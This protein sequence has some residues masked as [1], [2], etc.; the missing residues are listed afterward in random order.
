MSQPKSSSLQR[1]AAA[2]TANIIFGVLLT[3][4]PVH[5]DLSRISE[6]SLILTLVVEILLVEVESYL[7]P[8]FTVWNERKLIARGTDEVLQ[9]GSKLKNEAK[10]LMY[11]VWCY[12]G[13]DYDELRKY[14]Q[15]E[16][17]LLKKSDGRILKIH[18]L[19]NINEA[20]QVNVQHHCEEFKDEI[21]SEQYV[22]TAVKYHSR[23]V[24][25]VDRKKTLIL[26]QDLF[27][28]TVAGGI[29]PYDDSNWV[30]SYVNEYEEPEKDNAAHRL[31]IDASNPTKSVEDW[32]KLNT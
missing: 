14:F 2:I 27:S 1:F 6:D 15:Q 16:K 20:G 24:L 21:L 23:E 7:F 13:Y 3:C 32:I 30:A 10:K 22:V 9:R 19:I 18:R 28:K 12:S 31:K 8:A 26:C 5:F 17:E 25:I 29:G 4:V 11:G